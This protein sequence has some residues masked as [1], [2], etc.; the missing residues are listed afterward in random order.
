MMLE[1]GAIPR[2][3]GTHNTY[4]TPGVLLADLTVDKIKTGNC[5]SHLRNKQIAT[6]FR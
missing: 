6:I 4:I 1:D 2:A 5:K 3:I